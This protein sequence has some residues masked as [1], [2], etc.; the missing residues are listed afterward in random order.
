MMYQVRVAPLENSLLKNA[1]LLILLGNQINHPCSHKQGQKL[2]AQI[3]NKLSTPEQLALS[4]LGHTNGNH[5]GACQELT[6][7][8]KDVQQQLDTLISALAYVQ[9]GDFSSVEQAA[10]GVLDE[11]MKLVTQKR[12]NPSVHKLAADIIQSL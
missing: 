11:C 7:Q 8:I 4:T 3:T 12:V 5:T 9:K 2:V 6:D 10:L 1:E